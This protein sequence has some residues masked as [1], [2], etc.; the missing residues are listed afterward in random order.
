MHVEGMQVIS[1]I[2]P[3]GSQ[4]RFCAHG[5][6]AFPVCALEFLKCNQPAKKEDVSAHVVI[7]C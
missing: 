4:R 5:D 6:A 3:P 2:C 1:F 7:E